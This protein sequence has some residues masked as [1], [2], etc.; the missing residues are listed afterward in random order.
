MDNFEFANRIIE[1]RKQKGISQKELGDMLGVSNKA[2][3]KWENGE[4]MPKT[5]TML[6]LAEILGID[7][8]EL[9]GFEVKD[10][11]TP[12]YNNAEIDKLKSENAILTSKLNSI[13]KRRKQTLIAVIF[14]C[15]VGI[16]ASG[17]IA[18]C[19]SVNNDI[20]SNIEDVGVNGTKIVFS[21]ESF[22]APNEFQSYIIVDK[23]F[24]CCDKKYAEYY[25]LNGK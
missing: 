6:K 23:N 18:F 16:I 15:I 2:V 20:N 22:I 8:N 4:S 12:Q 7:G 5:S 13:N 14:I 24:E 10:N 19:F 21:N 3:S 25:D 9:I 1:L 11:V 17:I